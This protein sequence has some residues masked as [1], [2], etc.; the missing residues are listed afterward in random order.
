MKCCL[1][2]CHSIGRDWCGL[3]TGWASQDELSLLVSDHKF[4]KA[5]PTEDMEALKKLRVSISIQTDGTME[6]GL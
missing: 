1:E 2:A 5:L 6:Y 3:T 4:H